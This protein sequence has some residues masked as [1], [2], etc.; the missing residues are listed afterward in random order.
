MCLPWIADRPTDTRDF[1]MSAP[2]QPLPRFEDGRLRY[3]GGK[4]ARGNPKPFSGQV[5]TFYPNG[6]VCS[7][8]VF[9]DGYAV[10]DP[11]SGLAAFTV[12]RPGGSKLYESDGRVATVHLLD[13]RRNRVSFPRSLSPPLAPAPPR[14]PR[15][16]LSPPCREPP[17]RP[18]ERRRRRSSRSR[19]RSRDRRSS[20]GRSPRDCPS[21]NRR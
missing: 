10:D 19:I 2:D 13:G 14:A 5:H 20:S 18:A 4:D 6:A 1:H 21:R 11:A 8:S 16:P 12:W 9:R 3:Y 7:V 15:R 17:T